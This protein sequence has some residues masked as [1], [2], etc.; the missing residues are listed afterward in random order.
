[1]VFHVTGV[2][3]C[4]LPIFYR[5]S[6]SVDWQAEASTLPSPR[7]VLAHADLYVG[8]SLRFNTEMPG[9]KAS[10][11]RGPNALSCF[12]PPPERRARALHSGAGRGRLCCRSGRGA[13]RRWPLERPVGPG[14]R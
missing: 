11:T 14:Q 3:T 4:A 1:R 2:Q 13:V 6:L 5:F 8:V 7:P 9:K 10:L 12:S